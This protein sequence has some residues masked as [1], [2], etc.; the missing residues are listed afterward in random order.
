[1]E[2][3]K[4]FPISLLGEFTPV[5]H[6]GAGAFGSVWAVRRNS[7][8]KSYAIK[9][10]NRDLTADP[11]CLKRF[12]R[13][14]DRFAARRLHK[15]IVDIY[16]AGEVNGSLYLVMEL[17]EGKSLADI[18]E[19]SRPLDA[20]DSLQ[21]CLELANCL[22]ALHRADF[23][24]RDIKPDNIF[25]EPKGRPR[26]LDLGLARSL[27]GEKLTKTGVIIGSPFYMSPA[28][29]RGEKATSSDDVFAL[30]MTLLQCLSSNNPAAAADSVVALMGERAAPNWKV[31]VPVTCG[32]AV[33]KLIRWL[34]AA[35]P[36]NRPRDGKEAARAISEAMANLSSSAAIEAT[37][38]GED[39]SAERTSKCRKTKEPMMV[40]S[41]EVSSREKSNLRQ[42]FPLFFLLV[43]LVVGYKVFSA[44]ASLNT[45]SGPS[46]AKQIKISEKRGPWPGIDLLEKVA[47][48]TDSAKNARNDWA[49]KD[50]AD[51]GIRFLQRLAKVDWCPG[52][53]TGKELED[54]VNIPRFFFIHIADKE[55]EQ[56]NLAWIGQD[57]MPSDDDDERAVVRLWAALL[58][59]ND[60]KGVPPLIAKW[61]SRGKKLPQL[62][63]G[64]VKPNTSRL[65]AQKPQPDV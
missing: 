46:P 9:L 20:V 26:L 8:Q 5:N 52:K 35:D 19:E 21:I 25:I 63:K 50:A 4:N 16:D 34:T 22:A 60:R 10:F 57:K 12:E 7:D 3:E 1:M 24:H 11:L 44:P 42:L 59:H 64:A 17:I 36:K 41:K 14:R 29:C 54:L 39:K 37:I 43:V 27:G 53:M 6:L 40:L 31:A 51:D 47:S 58:A 23:V 33:T 38:K 62:V 32:G 65:F 45:K 18:L 13:E 30:G 48:K 49:L 2:N 61:Y 28:L 15:G 55:V 56:K